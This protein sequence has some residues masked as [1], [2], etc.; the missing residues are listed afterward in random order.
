[1]LLSHLKLLLICIFMLIHDSSEFPRT[2][3]LI[4][5]KMSWHSD[6]VTETFW[7]DTLLDYPNTQPVLIRNTLVNCES[8]L[9]Q[10]IFWLVFGWWPLVA[11]VSI[12]ASKEVVRNN[13]T[14]TEKSI[15][16]FKQEFSGEL[17][18]QTNR[19]KSRIWHLV[20]TIVTEVM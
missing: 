5:T 7:R 10:P 19:V 17:F 15:S 16:S 4:V 12:I 13:S 6:I 18:Y 1:M 11:V 20:L 9:F 14:K 8:S 2:A 3:R